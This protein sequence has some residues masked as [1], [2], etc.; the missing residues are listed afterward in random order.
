MA[1]VGK[2]KELSKKLAQSIEFDK[3]SLTRKETDVTYELD[4]P[5]DLFLV[6]K[7]VDHVRYHKLIR[8]AE[9]QLGIKQLDYESII[10][11][12]SSKNK[13]VQAVSKTT[14]RNE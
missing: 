4:Q 14:G 8:F 7:I 2:D 6:H 11:R 1:A 3:M 13:Q 5:L 10:A 9:S 12:K